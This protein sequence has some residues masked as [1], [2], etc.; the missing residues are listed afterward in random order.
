M[1]FESRAICRTQVHD[2]VEQV[3]PKVSPVELIAELVQVFLQIL[4][5]DS[6]VGVHQEHLRIRDGRMH[7]RQQLIDVILGDALLADSVKGVLYHRMTVARIHA[8]HR[9][10]V[11]I[12]H[13]DAH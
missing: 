12:I 4:F 11:D 13:G 2:P 10:P 1:M 9:I 6:V 8:D 3:F 5:L 7:P